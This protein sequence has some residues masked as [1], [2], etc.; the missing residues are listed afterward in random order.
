MAENIETAIVLNAKDNTRAAFSRLDKNLKKTQVHTK[1][2]DQGFNRISGSI[3]RA[4]AVLATFTITAVAIGS[5][6]GA[7]KRF[8]RQMAEISTLIDDAETSL[9]S[10]SEV[11][12]DL[13]RTYG[14]DFQSTTKA[15]YDT[16]SAGNSTVAEASKILT[17]ANVAA[18]AGVSDIA[19][20]TDALTTV[21]NSYGFSAD[22]AG[23]V[24]DILFK[25]IK[26]GKTTLTELAPVLGQVTS[27]AASM[28]VSFEEVG[29]VLATATAKGIRTSQAVTGLKATLANIIKPTKDAEDM[30]ARLRSIL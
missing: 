26:A 2:L 10:Y 23:R 24:S 7:A 1:Q 14:G 4:T 22:Q 9:T 5:S 11:V 12:D 16:I 30:M 28:G 27:T 20:A 13:I 21:I 17:A 15:L 18:I 8:G 19:T 25:T 29:A 6:I 3:I